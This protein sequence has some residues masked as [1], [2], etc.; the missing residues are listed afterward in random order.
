MLKYKNSKLFRQGIVGI[1]MIVSVILVGLQSTKFITL[2]TPV[3]YEAVFSEAGGLTAGADVIVSGVKVGTV[4]KV[5]LQ[6]GDAVATL[7]VDG[8]IG[9]GSESTAHI[10]TGSLLGKRIVTIETHG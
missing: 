1:V 2:T 5:S 6:D 10:R 3:H 7:S 9:L 4:S 8:K